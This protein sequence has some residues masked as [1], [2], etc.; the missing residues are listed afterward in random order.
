M[1]KGW[2]LFESTLY[3]A[4]WHQFKQVP[5]FISPD[6]VIILLKI[7]ILLISDESLEIS[8]HISVKF[9]FSKIK[10]Y[11]YNLAIC[12]KGVSLIQTLKMSVQSIIIFFSIYFA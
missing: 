8:Q 10:F 7:G 2:L 1:F 5:H 4:F 3:I 11:N 9:S 6:I 12:K